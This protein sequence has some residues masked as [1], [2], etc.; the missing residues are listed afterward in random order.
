[1]NR[2]ERIEVINRC[3]TSLAGSGWNDIDFLL[4]QFSLPTSNIWNDRSDD[5]EFNYVRTMLAQSVTDDNLI[6]LDDYLHSPQTHSTEDEPWNDGSAFRVFI[7]HLAQYRASAARLK[8]AIEW[9]GFD[10]FIAHKDINPGREWADVILAA[11]HSCDAFVGLVHAG[12]RESEWC[13]QE[14][15]FALGRTI[16]AIPI[17]AE[18][19]PHGF[20]G[21]IQAIP[22]PEG[23]NPEKTVA[24]GVIDV[25]LHD[26][27]TSAKAVAA[28]VAGL[29]GASSFGNANTLSRTLVDTD[30]VLSADQLRRLRIAQRDNPQVAGAWDVEAAIG[31]LEA[32][33]G[34]SVTATT[35]DL[36]DD[37]PF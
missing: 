22:W 6:A 26:K 27:R 10:A 12:F 13:D 8:S 37:I 14:V 4:G 30:A 17:R 9:W 19:D 35:S 31:A 15:G 16:P 7:S 20:F 3:A 32:R 11:L 24:R 25:L 34:K 28:V 36:A 2:A 18:V 5:T 29:E 1:M 21:H 23:D 33:S